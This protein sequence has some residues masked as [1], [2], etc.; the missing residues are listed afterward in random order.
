[1]LLAIS[2][3]WIDNLHL[4]DSMRQATTDRAALQQRERDLQA[5]L[6]DEHA[7]NARTASE[8]DQVRK[9]L[10]QLES[11]TAAKQL[12][13]LPVNVV[14]FVLGPQ[15]RGGTQVPILSLPQGTTRVDF[16]LDLETNDFPHYRAA[17]KSLQDD[18][19][20]WH[21][22]QLTAVTKGQGSA[23]SASV[24]AK[25]LQPQMY[26]LDLTGTPASGEG[27]L[28]SGYVFRVVTK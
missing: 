14:A 8:L 15:I 25:L 1:M 27:E 26:Q 13:S 23:L 22:G 2:A 3:L 9:S 4:R 12:A 24:P 6:S 5:Q 17:L 7:S 20:L 10:A 16:R 18:K 21:S 19:V 28:V 11:G